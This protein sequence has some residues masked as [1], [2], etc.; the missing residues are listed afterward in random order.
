[1][2]KTK[3][4][5]FQVSIEGKL[6]IAL[7][8][9]LGGVLAAGWGAAMKLRETIASN[10]AVMNV[11]PSALIQ[12]EK[13]RS[14]AESQ[15]GNS[16]AFF[17]MGSKAIFDKQKSDK[18]NLLQSLAEFEK[19][20]SLPQITEIVA[21]INELEKQ[22]QDYFDQA[23]EFRAKQTESKIV[24]QF[25]QSKTSPILTQ[26]NENFNQMVKLHNVSLDESRK[27][28]AQA[29][30]DAQSQIPKG[31]TWFS[32]AIAAL[33][34]CMSFI[35]LSML[36]TR[37]FLLRDRNRLVEEAKSAVL[38]RDEVISA[39]S[40]DL[41][42]PM[43]SLNAIAEEMKKS[44]DPDTTEQ[45]NLVNSTVAEMQ[46]H[47]NNIYDQK[48]ADMASLTLRLDQLSIA[49]I[50]DD[51]EVMLRPLAKQKL[52]T[53]H[54]DTVSQSLL[55]Y[56]DR[57]RIM[58]V[59]SN[60]IGNAI[61]FSPSHSRISVKVKSDAQFVN[62]SVIDNGGGIPDSR[63]DGIFDNFW[64]AKKTAEQGAGIGLAVVKTIVDAHGGTVRVDR[65]SQ[66]G[67]TITFTLPQRRPVNAQ[68]KKSW[69]VRAIN[70]GPEQSPTLM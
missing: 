51:T 27:N 20:H 56:F 44:S 43:D 5:L 10:A 62:I 8:V 46:G 53:L 57:E 45:A 66:N 19:K 48:K 69:T 49:E 60:L 28:A 2:S 24:G 16:R 58:R 38:A 39:L 17:V 12:V 11:D 64:Q 33:F 70:R 47:L 1:M 18:Q 25:Y 34:L 29:G 41:K 26:L 55:A 68:L 36:R 52:I 67:S 3:N 30:V 63:V 54:F 22:E 32:G 59:L 31:M 35:I 6:L 21:K 14:L 9:L 15:I 42:E 7:L 4:K 23:M 61:K 50:L 13:L 65:S 37:S 40:R